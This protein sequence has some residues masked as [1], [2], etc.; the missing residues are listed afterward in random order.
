MSIV[1]ETFKEAARASRVV[2][3][4][5]GEWPSADQRRQL[6]K[7]ANGSLIAI[8]TLLKFILGDTGDGKTPNHRLERALDLAVGLDELYVEILSRSQHLTPL[9]HHHIDGSPRPVSVCPFARLSK[10]L[11][12]EK[13]GVTTVLVGLYA[14]VHVPE[15]NL[16]PVTLFHS[17]LREFLT[18]E[19]RS[20]AFYVPPT[21]HKD[22]AYRYFEHIGSPVS[23]ASHSGTDLY[24]K[25]LAAFHWSKYV[26]LLRG[27]SAQLRQEL[28]ELVSHLLS[29]H[30][31][32]SIA[33]KKQASTIGEFLE[34]FTYAKHAV[35]APRFVQR[36]ID[37]VHGLIVAL[38]PREP[39]ESQTAELEGFWEDKTPPLA[40]LPPLL[41]YHTPLLEMCV[42]YLFA[43]REAPSKTPLVFLPE[44][45]PNTTSGQQKAIDASG[46]AFWSFGRHL[47]MAIRHD[48]GFRI[49]DAVRVP[50]RK[51][52]DTKGWKGDSWPFHFM[53]LQRVIRSGVDPQEHLRLFKANFEMG[54]LAVEGLFRANSVEAPA[55]DAHW[56]FK[57]KHKPQR[58]GH[59]W[60]LGCNQED[61]SILNLWA[62]DSTLFHNIDGK[63]AR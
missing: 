27:K 54:A 8:S 36:I 6:V 18:A 48:S 60:V 26:G 9:P 24:L 46:Y 11:G 34:S 52:P 2:R 41:P 51:H 62:Y 55:L 28:R 58:D 12:I 30:W 53:V 43:R 23:T 44:S 13:G 21:Q 10:L 63:I 19:D 56:S 20:K 38:T 50:G 33:G 4:Y 35:P 7:H 61:F 59:Y 57:S 1:D 32:T 5:G 47:A 25:N 31:I 45:T 3:A 42:H 40:N 29:T 16:A 39:P 14:I 15:D 49:M 17:S 37:A 22:L